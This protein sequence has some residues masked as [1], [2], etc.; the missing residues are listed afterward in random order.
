MSVAMT[1]RI[2]F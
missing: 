2:S 1:E